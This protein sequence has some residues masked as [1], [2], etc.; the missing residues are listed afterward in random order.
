MTTSIQDLAKAAAA[1]YVDEFGTSPIGESNWDAE[2]YAIDSGD[3]DLD[4]EVYRDTLHG[5]IER[6]QSMSI[7]ARIAEKFGNDGQCWQVG[8]DGE[9]LDDEGRRCHD[10][11]L[12]LVDVCAA[13]SYQTIESPDY[14]H[15]AYVFTDE[16]CIVASDGGWD[17]RAKGCTRW[18]WDGNGCQCSTKYLV[19]YQLGGRG[20]PHD[21]LEAA[22]MDLRESIAIARE[23]GD[24]QPLRL[25]AIEYPGDGSDPYGVERE[26]TVAEADKAISHAI[27]AMEAEAEVGQAINAQ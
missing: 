17:L 10:G 18:C 22:V 4:W 23:G 3:R 14:T 20:A 27:D 5:E 15:R 7:A 1:T 8:G 21:T 12:E 9:Y 11:A 26:L 25:T 13:E 19:A 2:A 16:S 6:L 24:C